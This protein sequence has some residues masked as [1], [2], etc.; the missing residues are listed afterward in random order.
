MA[1]FGD[2]LVYAPPE[3]PAEEVL[4]RY[5]GGALEAA[6]EMADLPHAEIDRRSRALCPPLRG[7]AALSVT[8]IPARKLSASMARVMCRYQPC[9]ERIS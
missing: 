6:D 4:E 2:G 8:R 7:V 9:Q 3:G 1:S 5:A